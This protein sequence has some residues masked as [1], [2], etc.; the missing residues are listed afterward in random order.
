MILLKH[1]QI[2]GAA[3]DTPG[4]VSDPRTRFRIMADI[5]AAV[6]AGNITEE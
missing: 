2:K 5:F 1:I 3:L 4:K 6:K